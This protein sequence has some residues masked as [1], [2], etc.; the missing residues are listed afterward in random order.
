MA[1]SSLVNVK[2]PA[3]TGNYTKGRTKPVRCITV[4]HMAGVNTAEGCGKIFQAVGRNGSSHYGIGYDGRIGLYVDEADT[5]WTNSN[6]ASNC[7]SITIETSNSATGGLWPVNETTYNSLV[8]LVAD[9]AKRNNL[10]TL[11]PGQNLTWHSMFT[12]TSCPGPFLRDRMGDLASRANSINSGEAKPAPTDELATA[13]VESLA[14][15]VIRGEYG[16]GE[17]RKK[18]LGDRYA[19][20]QALVNK[21]LMP[22]QD[23]KD[24]PVPEN[25]VGKQVVPIKL[26][27]VNGTPLHAYDPSYEVISDD[28]N[29]V[30]L[31]ARGAIWARL[32]KANVRLA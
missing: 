26:Q 10:G 23:K 9:I 32:P 24:E 4:H 5:A 19:E 8:K 28:G 6:W 11:I 14:A 12:A 20:V 3:Y 16:N 27:D 29:T 31:K 1:S 22:N 25:L 2:V 21:M 17:A 13:T 18:A 15:A 7:E 30:V